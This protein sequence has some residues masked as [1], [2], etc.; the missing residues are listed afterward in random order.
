M[1]PS[2]RALAAASLV[3]G[4]VACSSGGSSG[5]SGGGSG[6][7]GPGSGTSTSSSPQGSG[8]TGQGAGT[9]ASTGTSTGDPFEAS[10]EACIAHINELR[11]T[12]GKA[13]YG[14]WTSAETCV[15]QE[16]TQD[17]MNNSPHGAWLSGQFSCNGNG[18]NECLGQGTTPDGIV[19]CLDQMWA[20]K[21]QAG[22]AG[23]DACADAY[24]PNCPNCDFYGMQTG[25]VCGHYVNMSANY[26]TMAACGFSQL[27][28]WDA[29]N[30]E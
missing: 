27:G 30:F 10:R 23:C 8:G 3:V 16:A 5:S 26:F 24:D 28:G 18:Q 4:L 13:A 11:A 2:L 29:I 20:E 22:C 6:G 19:A 1:L 14:R 17:E 9:P 21:D 15:D 7:T 25:Q 12:E